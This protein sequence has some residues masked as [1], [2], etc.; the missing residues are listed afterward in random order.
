MIMLVHKSKKKTG[1]GSISFP[2][3]QCWNPQTLVATIIAEID[4]ERINCRIKVSELEKMFPRAAKDPM[5]GITS[6]RKDIEKVARKLIEKNRFEA[7]GSIKIHLDDLTQ[8]LKSPSS[9][10]LKLNSPKSAG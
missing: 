4:G 3:L 8:I 2:D 7:D 5:Q 10:N 9:G 1:D 6:H